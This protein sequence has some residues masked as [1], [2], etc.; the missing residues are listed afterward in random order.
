MLD[1]QSKYGVGSENRHNM[2]TRKRV[3]VPARIRD[4]L[5]KDLVVSRDIV[6]DRPCLCI[7]SAAGWD[8]RVE[9]TLEICESEDERQEVLHVLCLCMIPA[10]LDE[11]GRVT[12]TKQLIDHAEIE[13]E[14][15]IT[16]SGDHALMWAASVYDEMNSSYNDI[17]SLKAILGRKRP[18]PES[19]S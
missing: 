9:R 3:F 11:Q 10:E 15:V 14:V 19:R 16:G 7:Y 6:R 1:M 4:L 12:M 8:A 17:A 5:G 2:D 13:K 18:K